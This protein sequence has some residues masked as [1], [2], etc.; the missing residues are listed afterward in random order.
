MK[1]HI[2]Y[3]GTFADETG[4]DVVDGDIIISVLWDSLYKFIGWKGSHQLWERTWIVEKIKDGEVIGIYDTEKAWSKD[5]DNKV[6]MAWVLKEFPYVNTI[7][8]RDE[9]VKKT[10]D[11]F[12]SI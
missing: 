6:I 8:I 10:L 1:K 5:I 11:K 7:M 4:Y 9:I 2:A 3:S 12:G